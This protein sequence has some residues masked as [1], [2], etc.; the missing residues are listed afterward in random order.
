MSGYKWN[1]RI[2]W[3]SNETDG[4]PNVP[5]C[6]KCVKPVADYLC[7][8]E[9]GSKIT[10]QTRGVNVEYWM[11]QARFLMALAVKRWQPISQRGLT[12]DMMMAPEVKR[13]GGTLDRT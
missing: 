5:V 13:L 10:L 1:C 11:D 2:C 4:H 8:E 7:Q 9:M 12:T 3:E 6:D